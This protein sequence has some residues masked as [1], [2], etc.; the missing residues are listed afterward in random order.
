MIILVFFSAIETNKN[1]FE[2]DSILALTYSSRN[3]RKN[4]LRHLR[5]SLIDVID[6]IYDVRR[7]AINNSTTQKEVLF[8]FF[9]KDFKVVKEYSYSPMHSVIF[10]TK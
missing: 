1:L 9:E 2:R 6:D 3:N 10:K 4:F 5:S 7:L 8:N